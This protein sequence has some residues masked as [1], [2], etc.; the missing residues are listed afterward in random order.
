MNTIRII[1]LIIAAAVAPMLG[2]W[3]SIGAPTQSGIDASEVILAI[4]SSLAYQSTFL[5]GVPLH[6]ILWKF[7]FAYFWV[8]LLV[9]SVASILLFKVSFGVVGAL[10]A[11]LF[12]L[13]AA[14]GD[15]GLV[16]V[17]KNRLSH[18]GATVLAV[19]FPFF[20]IKL[21][22]IPLR[23]E[24]IEGVIAESYDEL[25]IKTGPGYYYFLRSPLIVP[26]RLGSRVIVIRNKNIF[27]K[28]L[29]L[30]FGGYVDSTAD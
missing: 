6:L 25:M 18:A 17:S 2:V 8:Y 9:G 26:E 4:G 12:W 7:R 21:E 22:S 11:G 29:S 14:A 3:L 19:C 1:R 28:E 30:E 27:G 16:L 23:Q 13:I 15:K 20:M 24:M 10:V 5:L